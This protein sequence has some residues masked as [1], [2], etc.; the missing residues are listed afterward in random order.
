[1]KEL[2]DINERIDSNE[3]IVNSLI[4][5]IGELEKREEKNTDYTLHFEALQKIFEVFLVRYNKENA[6]LK[7]TVGL[8]NTSYPAEQIQ[9]ALAEIKSILEVIRKSLPVKVKHEFD[10]KTK[11]WII[12]GVILLI[13]TAISTGLCGY[14][15][16][17][18]SRMQANDIKFRA[19][20]QVYPK[21]ANWADKYYAEQP[22]AM[23]DTTKR[24]ENE[25][26]ERSQAND[27]SNQERRESKK[28]VKHLKSK[29]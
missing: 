1:M 16:T 9:N 10:F 8:L 13:V 25:A 2:D 3:E 15:L 12:A 5:K 26:L 21:Q 22:D 27:L 24:L 20:R 7:A 23:K 4:K 14:L 19:I 11:G 28:L 29:S 17:E 18:N 6:E